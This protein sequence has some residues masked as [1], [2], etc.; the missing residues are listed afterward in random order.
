MELVRKKRLQLYAGRSNPS[1]GV[2]IACHLGEEL[3][4][5]NLVDFASGEIGCE[6]GESVRGADTFVIQTH[7]RPVNASIMEQL[8][9]IDAAR[10]ASAKSI[11]A[12]CPFYG[13]SRQDRKAEGREPI[14]ARLL[15]DL[16]GT[17]GAERIVSVDLHTGQIQGFFDGP[18]DHLTALPIF[19]R[20]LGERVDGDAVVVSPDAG[21]IKV[22][23][24]LARQLGAGIAMVHKRHAPGA[25]N[26]VEARDVVGEVAGRTCVIV[27][28]MIDTGGTICAAAE[29]LCDR[30]A[31]EIRAVAT[32]GLFSGS[33]L[34]RL[35]DSPVNRVAVTDTLPV[36]HSDGL[37]VLSV[38]RMIAEAVRAVFEENSVS[39]IFAG[40]NL[41]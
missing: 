41:G 24:R 22:A 31:G 13:Y 20:Y 21:R 29:I 40:Q 37:D 39:E 8:I 14:T 30:G 12:V 38:A 15:A 36:A 16:M 7:S 10:R 2:E 19:R 23:E 3:G 27:D 18:V 34:S 35:Q 6:L 9:M 32:H 25:A 17:A 33:A 4:H 5:P 28:D 26:V 11:T 1:L